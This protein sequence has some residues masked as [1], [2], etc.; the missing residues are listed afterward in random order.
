MTITCLSHDPQDYPSMSM[1][2]KKMLDESVFP[3]FG[4]VTSRND[5]EQ[6]VYNSYRV[7]LGR[8][9]MGQDAPPSVTHSFLPRCFPLAHTPLSTL[10]FTA[11]TPAL[12]RTSI[13]IFVHA[14]LHLF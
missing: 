14:R 9:W 10:W 7:S 5:E 1:V 3:V 11:I 2:A 13:R 12:C 8:Q 4:V 6:L